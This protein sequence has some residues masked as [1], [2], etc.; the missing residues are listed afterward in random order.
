L[1]LKIDGGNPTTT[2]NDQGGFIG[3]VDTCGGK[4]SIVFTWY[5]HGGENGE[6]SGEPMWRGQLL[7]R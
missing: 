1:R 7:S 6:E 2:L 4:G 3:N 5:F